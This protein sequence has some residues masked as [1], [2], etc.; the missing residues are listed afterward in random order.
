MSQV[1]TVRGSCREAVRKFLVWLSIGQDQTAS[2]NTAAYCKARGR[3]PFPD[4]EKVHPKVV[5]AIESAVPQALL[6]HG[7]S[8]KV[9]DGSSCSMPDTLKNQQAYPQ[10]KGQKPG[11]GFPI[12]RFVGL[13]SL[14]TGV[15][16]GWA[17]G[18]LHSDERSLFRRLWDLLHSGD[19]L[20]GDCGFT[21]YADLYLLR[22]AGVDSVL[23]NHQSRK[24]GLQ[25]VKSLGKGNRLVRWF[26]TS[27][28]PKTMDKDLWRSIPSSIV[29]REF[30]FTAPVRGWR[31]QTFVIVTTLTDAKAFPKRELAALYHQRWQA[32]LCF[33]DIKVALQMDPLTCKSPAMIQKEL[34]LYFIAYNLIRAVMLQAASRHDLSPLSLS[35]QGA[36]STL[37]S[38]APVLASPGLSALKR[39]SLAELLLFYL[40]RDPVP[41]RP[42]RHEPRARKR[43]PKSYQL[44]T[45]PRRLFL[46]IPHRNKYKSGLS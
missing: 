5:Q 13:F 26:K 44:L 32:E 28:C 16:I 46:E 12:L 20:L 33:R 19:I 36:V 30:T 8:V 1:L 4:L 31:T 3:L 14:F 41:F 15:L 29:L 45:K 9:V 40:A 37:R 17:T 21:S 7:R 2:P 35:F 34:A 6:W 43:R 22:L 11:C 25:T 10:H 23:R 42:G 27:A 39:K 38:W 24:R 18:N